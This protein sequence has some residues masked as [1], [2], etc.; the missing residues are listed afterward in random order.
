MFMY[1][2]NE[3][4]L[5]AI[6]SRSNQKQV[7]VCK[8]AINL[9]L[10]YSLVVGLL[11]SIYIY[12]SI[13]YL[14]LDVI[15]LFAQNNIWILSNRQRWISHY[16]PADEFVCVLNSMQQKLFFHRLHITKFMTTRLFYPGIYRY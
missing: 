15:L 3:W 16:N 13:T 8:F 2:T 14:Y 1:I 11:I 12:I 7:C 5:L 4:G 6:R 9:G 10:N